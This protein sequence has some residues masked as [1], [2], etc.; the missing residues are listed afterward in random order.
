MG[1]H[2]K[3]FEIQKIKMISLILK[4]KSLYGLSPIVTTETLGIWSLSYSQTICCTHS[5]RAF[6]Y[7][8][9]LVFGFQQYLSSSQLNGTLECDIYSV[10]PI[11]HSVL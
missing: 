10:M 1:E 2:E 4:K 7:G 9:G 8:A 6:V 5:I 3:L 11:F